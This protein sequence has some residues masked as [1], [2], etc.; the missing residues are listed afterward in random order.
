LLFDWTGVCP[1]VKRIWTPAWVLYSGGCCFFFM[2]AFYAVCD[3]AGLKAWSYPLRVV[4]ANSIF[5]Y[6]LAHVGEAYMKSAL[7]THLGVEL[8]RSFGPAYEMFL[9]GAGV[10]LL[11]W[12]LLWWMY[13][14]RLF[15][16]I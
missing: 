11:W 15:V 12:L 13:R 10:L 14:Q 7:Q 16:K 4:G 5:A 6:V 9:L 3:V 2:A 8:F 1:I